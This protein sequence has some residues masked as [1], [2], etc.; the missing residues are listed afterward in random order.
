MQLSWLIEHAKATNNTTDMSI[1]IGDVS[2][3]SLKVKMHEIN[4]NMWCTI[5]KRRIKEM[6]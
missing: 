2:I 5:K 4:R 1:K 6:R 3:S